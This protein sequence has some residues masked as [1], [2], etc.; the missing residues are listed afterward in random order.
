ME[1]YDSVPSG[2]LSK[3]ILVSGLRNTEIMGQGQHEM[4]IMNT[5]H[6]VFDSVFTLVV[7]SFKNNNLM[8]HVFK[9]YLILK[10]FNKSK[11]RNSSF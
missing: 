3:G 6:K 10:F 1:E 11:H 9:L 4:E 7:Q 8:S 2:I 5:D